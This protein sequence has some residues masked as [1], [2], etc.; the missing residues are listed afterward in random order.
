MP[1][2]NLNHISRWVGHAQR[3]NPHDLAIAT[4]VHIRIVEE[5]MA[6]L[7]QSVTD[8]QVAVQGVSD[9][10]AAGGQDLTQALADAQA[11]NAALQAAYQQQ[12][13]DDA[14]EDAQFQATIDDLNAQLATAT[15]QAQAA[16]D[17][18]QTEVANLNNI[19]VGQPVNPPPVD[20]GLDPSQ[21][22]PPSDGP[23]VNPV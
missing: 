22:A 14:V 13:S 6:D 15:A 11:A 16:A 3:L 23:V 19:A 1:S 5:M 18:I 8:L 4:Y 9:R 10:L 12:L 20:T 7:Q 17:A 2:P 21:G